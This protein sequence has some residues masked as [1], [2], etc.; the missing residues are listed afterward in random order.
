MARTI[1]EIFQ[2]IQADAA[3]RAEL[4]GLSN[5]STGL[6]RLWAYVAATA[7]WTLET[8][9]DRFRLDVDTLVARAPV[10]T[11]NW[12]AD[13]A[14]LWQ[15]GDTLQVI[16][17]V[18][19]YP[20]TATGAKLVT[21]AT[22]KENAQ[23][24]RLFIKVAKDGAT[25][26]TLAALSNAELVQL[27]G[28][29]DRIRFAGTRLEVV[30]READRLQLMGEVYYDALLDV[31]SVQTAVR[32]ALLGYLG[33]LEF[34]GQVFVAK[35]QDAIQAVP[36]VRDVLLSRVAARV[37]QVAPV[38]FARVYETA[39][40]YIVEEDLPGQ[41]FTDTLTFLPYANG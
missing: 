13:K 5:S 30:S 28:Y 33:Q 12:Y 14:L 4:A 37:G 21:R 23:T 40:G 32:T 27:R 6:S 31:A 25:A 36:G 8:F 18:V 10:G 15:A 17:N 29:F 24:G 35:L 26:G 11:P 2:A 1:E 38:V 34:D 9:W 16:D 22:A 7:G 19:S 3:T 20:A 41:S 39:A